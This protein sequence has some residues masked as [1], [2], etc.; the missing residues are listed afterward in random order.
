[1]HDE[2]DVPTIS[3]NGYAEDISQTV[4]SAEEELQKIRKELGY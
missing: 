1:M 3:E 2:E 4:K